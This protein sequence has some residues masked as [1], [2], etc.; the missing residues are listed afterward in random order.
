MKNHYSVKLGLLGCARIAEEALIKPT[1]SLPNVSLVG[2]ASRNITKAVTY[3]KTHQIP[4]YYGSYDELLNDDDINAV[5]IPL[6]NH[7]HLEWVVKA[8][9]KGKHILVEKPLALNAEEVRQMIDASQK[10]GVYLLEGLWIQHT[11]L[12]KKCVELVTSGKWGPVKH[13]SARYT[14]YYPRY[15]G[16]FHR[17]RDYSSAIVPTVN[18]CARLMKDS[19]VQSLS[20][21]K[22]TQDFRRKRATGGGCM[23]DV[24]CYSLQ[25]IHHFS[26]SKVECIAAE[27]DFSGPDGCDWTSSAWIKFENGI[28]ANFLVS[29]DMPPAV[30]LRVILEGGVISVPSFIDKSNYIW[31]DT[32]EGQEKISVPELNPYV[33]QLRHFVNVIQG[34]E[35]PISITDSLERIRIMDL[36]FTKVEKSN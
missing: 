21:S 1:A 10:N 3:S 23:Y 25:M 33:E 19:L 4:G 17:H 30:S 13:I 32:S 6:P 34:Q 14:Y 12:F 16:R 5:Y 29:F 27:A 18:L 7:L 11:A 26:R 36:C 28:T 22:N 31:I 9:E 15:P 2:V 8:A 24:G 20:R 35:Q